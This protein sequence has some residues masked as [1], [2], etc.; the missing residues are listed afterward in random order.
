[1]HGLVASVRNTSHA[2]Q[3]HERLYNQHVRNDAHTLMSTM[4]SAY[5][6]S[7]FVQ[8]GGKGEAIRNFTVKPWNKSLSKISK[9]LI[10]Y[11]SVFVC[12]MKTSKTWLCRIE[13]YI[14]AH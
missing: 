10:V 8:V 9:H 6:Q 14:Y 12:T 1:M 3:I 11:A 4:A 2:E 5:F 13:T 7:K